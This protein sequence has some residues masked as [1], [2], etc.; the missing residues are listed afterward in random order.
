M[1]VICRSEFGWVLDHKQYLDKIY[2][3]ESAQ[4]S[5]RDLT[6]QFQADLFHIKS[7]F[8]MD[9]QFAATKER[10][11]EEGESSVQR[12]RKK[13]KAELNW[14]ELKAADYHNQIKDQ[15]LTAVN[16][17]LELGK[18]AGY[19]PTEKNLQD[20]DNNLKARS[21]M[22]SVEQTDD[23]LQE[24]CYQTDITSSLHLKGIALK[25]NDSVMVS[26]IINRPVHYHGADPAVVSLDDE[27]YL[28]PPR[29]SFLLS[30]ISCLGLLETNTE[31]PCFD[32]IV[33]DPPWQNKSVKRLKK[34]NS[35]SNEDLLD[36]PIPRLGTDN[37]LV[38]VWVTNRWQ[39]IHFIK[40]TLFPGW[41]VQFVAE[42]HWVKVTKEGEMV[43]AFDSPHRKP[44]EVLIIGRC[45]KPTVETKT[46][47]VDVET[48]LQQKGISPIPKSQ[49]IVSVPCCL[50]SVKPPLQEVM[51]DYLPLKPHC[52]EL[53][54]RN[55]TPDWTSWGNQVLKHQHQKYF[56]AVT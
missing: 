55:L 48:F 31:F 1:A 44:Y 16:T 30:D 54:A 38:V 36:I 52:L 49:C 12:K 15:V 43:Y 22:K 56:D 17:L 6:F 32:M 47:D 37:S 18:E 33:M 11:T 2:S 41:S 5:G 10:T 24:S 46:D 42:W 39:H 35:I 34:Y 23:H 13:R 51:K 27:L 8:M 7:P 21:A 9:S 3:Q 45:R 4:S 20:L 53:F 40:D 26:S 28:L 29:C 14:G 19:F 50:H 25:N